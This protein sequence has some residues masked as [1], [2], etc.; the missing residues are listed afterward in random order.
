MDD[1]SYSVTDLIMFIPL[2]YLTMMEIRSFFFLTKKKSEF[3]T[4]TLNA[5]TEHSFIFCNNLA[6]PSCRSKPKFSMMKM[7]I[8]ER[9]LVVMFFLL[10]LC[11]LFISKKNGNELIL[12][13]QNNHIRLVTFFKPNR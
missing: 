12:L 5:K 8:L 4:P 7:C 11:G 2:Q 13:Q 6:S 3:N 10:Y 9:I 1:L